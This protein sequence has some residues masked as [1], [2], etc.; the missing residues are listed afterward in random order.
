MQPGSLAPQFD[1]ES[2]VAGEIKHVALSQMKG[3]WVV[4]FFYPRDFTFICPTEIK[5]FSNA[6][7]EFAKINAVVVAASTDSAYSH[8]AWFERDLPD[9]KFPVLADTTH[10]ISR[11]YGVLNEDTGEAYRGTFIVDPEGVVKYFV[12]SDMNVGRSVEETL[13]VLQAFQTGELCG[14]AWKPGADFVHKS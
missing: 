1:V 14:L 3:K 8:K 10:K 9:V 11:E 6:E 12:I 13:R 4:L 2:Y 5:G 7:P